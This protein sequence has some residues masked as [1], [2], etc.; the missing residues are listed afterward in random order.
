MDSTKKKS[1]IKQ[2][3]STEV[4]KEVTRSNGP[5]HNFFGKYQRKQKAYTLSLFKV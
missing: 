1:R 4:E 5:F 2:P 3:E